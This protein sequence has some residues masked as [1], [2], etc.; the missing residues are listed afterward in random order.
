VFEHN[1]KHVSETRGPSN[2][3][4]GLLFSAVF[5]IIGFYPL[6]G[7]EEARLWSFAVAVPFLV[8]AFCIPAALTPAN[9]LW[10]K[11]GNLMHRIVSPVALSI[12]F[13]STVLPT[14]LILRLLGKD[15]LRLRLEPAVE[16]YWIKREPPGP[17]AESFNN[18]F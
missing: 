18:Q 5:G 17:T 7:G 3:S 10:M 4:F 8:L 15:P 11:F 9:W 12:I 16:S 1:P 14:G 6:L 13:F 2:R